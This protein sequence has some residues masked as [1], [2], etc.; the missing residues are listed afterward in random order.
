MS[1]LTE[2]QQR[3]VKDIF[4]AFV[5]DLTGFPNAINAVFPKTKI[6]LCTVHMVCNSLKYVSYKD[7][8]EVAKN[9]KSI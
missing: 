7:R 3:G 6:Q 2:L 8:K 5:D 9:L 4:I 1:V